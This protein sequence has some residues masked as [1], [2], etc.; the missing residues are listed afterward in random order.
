MPQI[1]VR[2]DAFFIRFFPLG[3]WGLWFAC[4]VLPVGGLFNSIV[5][6]KGNSVFF[7]CTLQ[8]LF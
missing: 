7:S 5:L 1:Q 6:K 8:L 4:N 2:Q 3:R